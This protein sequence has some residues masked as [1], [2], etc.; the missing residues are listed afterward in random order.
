MNFP[1]F[2][3]GCGWDN[4]QTLRAC[5]ALFVSTVC[6]LSEWG[7]VQPT[8]FWY[9]LQACR[10]A[11]YEALQV[12]VFAWHFRKPRTFKLLALFCGRCRPKALAETS[13]VLLNQ[14]SSQWPQSNAFS[15]SLKQLIR[16]LCHPRLLLL[17]QHSFL[18]G[19]HVTCGSARASEMAH[20]TMAYV[21]ALGGGLCAAMRPN[22]HVVVAWQAN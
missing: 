3:V 9:A 21:L 16:C 10:L 18:L 2:V 22:A 6:F 11:N 7:V 13:R 1:A 14:V 17:L 5:A 4:L 15:P 8:F 19:P 20:G 12:P